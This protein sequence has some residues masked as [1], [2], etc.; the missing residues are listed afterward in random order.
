[1]SSA[2]GLG[3]GLGVNALEAVGAAGSGVGDEVSLG[4]EVGVGTRVA[5]STSVGEAVALGSS[6]AVGD[7]VAEGSDGGVVGC[8]PGVDEGRT[9]VAVGWAVGSDGG[10]VGLGS[11]GGSVGLGMGGASVGSTGMS[12][13]MGV[14]MVWLKWPAWTA[15]PSPAPRASSQIASVARQAKTRARPLTSLSLTV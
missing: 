7:I 6:V 14:G 3:V 13:E 10:F 9:A 5:V 15:A 4:T 12:E 2:S 11:E 1:M 8:G